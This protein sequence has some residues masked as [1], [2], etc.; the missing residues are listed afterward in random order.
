V[1]LVLAT[2]NA[3]KIRE[4]SRLLEGSGVTLLTPQDLAQVPE[5]IEDGATFEANALKKARA[6]ARAGA[7]PALADDSGLCVDALGGRPGVHSARFG[8]PGA[9]DAD[10]CRLLLEELAPVPDNDRGAAFVCVVAVC[11][12][13]G[14][15]QT[16]EGRCQ[17]VI[18]R[19]PRGDNGF[20]Y[21]P[22]FYVPEHGRTMAQLPLA[23]K[24]Q[25][26]HR[27]RALAAA[28]KELIPFLRA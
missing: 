3:G 18:T 15:C 24:N 27:G 9:T 16:F 25:I 7:L 23:V 26:S 21:D 5:V 20:G 28:V 14:T 10:R 4:I 11:R 12:P 22:V 13:D 6:F 17:G 2:G 1:K 19:E 8:G